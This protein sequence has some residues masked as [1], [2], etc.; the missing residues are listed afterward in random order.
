METVE[1]LS[2]HT[3]NLV[4]AARALDYVRFLS[5]CFKNDGRK[6]Q[7]AE[8]F[9]MQNPRS[10]NLEL[11]EKAAVAAGSTTDATW[12]GPLAP[13]NA[14]ADSFLELLRPATIL[15]RIPNLRKVPFNVGVPQQTAAGSYG[16]TGQG[17]PTT[18]TKADFATITLG[19]AKTS[20]IIVVTEELAKLSLPG[21][22]TVL[23]DEL[24]Q[25]MARFLD[26]QFVDETVAAVA[27]VSPASILNGTVAIVSSGTSQANAATDLEALLTAFVTANA[28][29]E[30]MVLLMKPANA[31][32]L[33][34]A[35]NTPTLG[36][37][38]GSIYGVP[39]VC[40][41]N[42]GDRL[43][44][45]DAQGILYAD[46]NGVEIDASRNAVVQM[47]GTP[48]NPGTASTVMVSMYQQNFVSFRGV[49]WINWKRAALS[50]AKFVSGA[51]YV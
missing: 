22:E 18:V 3:A 41:N 42:V 25:G 46:D 43:I 51:A 50:S 26:L 16:W 9:K 8:V 14:L 30:S 19:V 13:T 15:G 11:V 29:V 28:N 33:A 48:D 34:R 49:R 27:N 17:A 21:S 44:A 36:L 40:S 7:A 39:V 23:R 24:I 38:G 37:R 4:T 5:L 12:A 6:M 45:I 20:G 32:A 31:I 1:R 35:T 47:D 2:T 10:V